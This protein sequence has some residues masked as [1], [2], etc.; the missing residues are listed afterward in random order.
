MDIRYKGYLRTLLIK[1]FEWCPITGFKNL[2]Y[3]QSV[4]HIRTDQ[5][6]HGNSLMY[7][8][9]ICT[10]IRFQCFWA[11]KK[12]KGVAHDPFI[13]EEPNLK[14]CV[15][16]DTWPLQPENNLQ[17]DQDHLRIQNMKVSSWA[18]NFQ[19]PKPKI[20]PG[21]STIIC[22]FPGI[23]LLGPLKWSIYLN[24]FTITSILHILTFSKYLLL[25]PV[26]I[27]HENPWKYMDVY[28]NM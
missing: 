16:K 2:P 26:E 14:K 12:L 10:Q 24:I 18:L 21:S 13:F 17:R 23:V 28:G 15:I 5:W 7:R 20:D 27:G 3:T 11:P 6:N 1:V 19:N 4:S 22:P 25:Y 8:I 9:R